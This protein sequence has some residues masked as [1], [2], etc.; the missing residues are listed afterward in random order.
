MAWVDQSNL[1]ESKSNEG[2]KQRDQFTWLL[3]G[4]EAELLL[5]PLSN[6]PHSLVVKLLLEKKN[7]SFSLNHSLNSL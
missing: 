4:G 5:E 3:L 1:C 2:L 7:G 6:L